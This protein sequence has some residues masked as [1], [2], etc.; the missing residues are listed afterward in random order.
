MKYAGYIVCMIGTPSIPRPA[1]ELPGTPRI[2]QPAPGV[3][4][5]IAVDVMGWVDMGS[6]LLVVDALEQPELAEGVF[7]SMAESAGADKPPRIIL[8]THLHPDHTALN[9]A[10][11]GTF[12]AR[13]VNAR[14]AL[15]P[16]E[17][18]TFTGDNGRRVQFI[19]LPGCHT[20]EDCIAWLPDDR[21]LFAGDLF[22][23]GLIPWD[24]PL[25]AAKY[26]LLTKT[27]RRLI[28]FG[29]E[30]VV[31]GHGPAATTAE[32]R[33]QLAYYEELPNAVRRALADGCSETE[34]VAGG[35]IPP[36][37]EMRDWWRFTLWKHRDSLKKVCRAIRLGRL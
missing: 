11:A 3:F 21:V 26:A 16:P 1:P 9:A 12:G 5:R 10:F 6:W 27:Y 8:N 17:G 25:D 23:W 28:A 4:V 37:D 19:P 15:P 20:E 29:A 34:I 24:R 7:R 35:A 31:A 14:T 22:N 2:E 32:L 30:T 33:H 13:I 18:R 36:P